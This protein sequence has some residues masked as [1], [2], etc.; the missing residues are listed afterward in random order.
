MRPGRAP[1]ARLPSAAA[2]GRP[3]PGRRCWRSAGFTPVALGPAPAGGVAASGAGRSVAGL[4][5]PPEPGEPGQPWPVLAEAEALALARR[6]GRRSGP[7]ARCGAP[8]PGRAVGRP[9]G[10]VAA[11]PLGAPAP[12]PAEALTHGLAA[13]A[14]SCFHFV[15]SSASR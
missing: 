10:G 15:A 4:A 8:G 6:W 1:R 11:W 7:K 13:C 9:Q 3:G 12:A 5:L 2:L 14:G